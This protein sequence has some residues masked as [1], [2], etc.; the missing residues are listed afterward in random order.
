MSAIIKIINAFLIQL[1]PN[2][3]DKKSTTA[4]VSTS[5]VGGLLYLKLDLFKSK[6][7]PPSVWFQGDEDFLQMSMSDGSPLE[8]CCP[9]PVILTAEIT[10]K[11]SQISA[12]PA[13]SAVNS[14]NN[15]QRG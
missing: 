4:G 10:E 9:N 13:Y 15:T 7:P 14:L 12:N 1:T 3:F 6:K 2:H 5:V 11:K 8:C